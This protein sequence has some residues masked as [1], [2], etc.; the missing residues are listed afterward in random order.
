MRKNNLICLLSSMMLAGVIS[1]ASP[2]WA[3]DT[4]AAPLKILVVDV[5]SVLGRASAATDIQKQLEG[6]RKSYQSQIA[7]QEE[8]LQA[9]RDELDRQRGVLS[10]EAFEK[11]QK[12]FRSN[13]ASAQKSVQEKKAALE[14]VFN[15]SMG[16]IRKAVINV[17]AQ[18]AKE[19]KANLVLA[20]QQVVLVE[21]S[22]DITDEVLDRLN[23][24]Y[25]AGSLKV[26]EKPSKAR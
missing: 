1:V 4:A 22:M 20:N 3:E 2:A 11:K 12:E 25:P 24:K 10:Q 14:S 8:K 19:R 6:Q 15:G 21:K 18:I 17:V 16:E 5:P 9:A 23:Q 7:A 26:T 13:L